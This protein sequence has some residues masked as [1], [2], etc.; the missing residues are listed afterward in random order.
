[1]LT[2]IL[3][4]L[5]RRCLA[6]ATAIAMVAGCVI[7]AGTQPVSAQTSGTAQTASR[8]APAIPSSSSD[9]CLANANGSCVGVPVHDIAESVIALIVGAPAWI[10]VYW[11]WKSMGNN[12]GGQQGEEQDTG[13]SGDGDPD[14]GLCLA[15]TGGDAYMTSCGANGTVWIAIPHNDGYWLYS[16][17]T[18]NNH[19]PEVLTSNSTGDGAQLFVTISDSAPGG[20]WQTWNWYSTSHT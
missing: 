1:M 3:K 9:I 8:A 10:L 6:L 15:D 12:D 19:N 14:A 16:R 20:P 18:V 2:L 13:S 11:K 5:R 7:V 17:Y 4:K